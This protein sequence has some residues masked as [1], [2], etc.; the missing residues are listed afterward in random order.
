MIFFAGFYWFWDFLSFLY[1]RNNIFRK[2]NYKYE[3]LNPLYFRRSFVFWRTA[4]GRFSQCFFSN[5]SSLV[6]H[7]GQH[8]YSAPPPPLPPR[9]IKKLPT[10]LKG[11]VKVRNHCHVTAKYTCVA[12]RDCDISVSL[13]YKTFIVFHI[14]KNYVHLIMQELGKFDFKINVI[15]NRLEKYKSFSL[16][17]KLVFIDSFH[18]LS[19]SLDSL[20]KKLGVNDVKYLSQ[21]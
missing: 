20:V 16:D 9:T 15:P 2:R 17:S 3:I 5:F 18:F 11:D 19:F 8:F 12:H 6:N 14:L 10:V 4:L 1:A 21:E 13:N 7:G